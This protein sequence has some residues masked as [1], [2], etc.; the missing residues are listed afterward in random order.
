M[1][2]VTVKELRD[3]LFDIQN[4]KMTIQELRTLLFNLNGQFENVNAKLIND[5]EFKELD[6]FVKTLQESK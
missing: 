2:N 4:Q 1:N 6:N 3:F 5:A